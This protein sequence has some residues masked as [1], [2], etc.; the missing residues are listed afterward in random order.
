[1]T[2]HLRYE[3]SAM[4]V[5]RLKEYRYGQNM[6]LCIYD[7]GDEEWVLSYQMGG[8]VGCL[9][10]VHQSTVFSMGNRLNDN[11]RR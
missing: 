1:M 9:D 7:Y 8:A 5:I 6:I 3:V 4:R 2:G 11:W 10:M